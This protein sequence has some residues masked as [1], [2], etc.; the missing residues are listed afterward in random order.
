MKYY[1]FLFLICVFSACSGSKQAVENEKSKTAETKTEIKI[2]DSI[3]EK[4]VAIETIKPVNSKPKINDSLT[5][6]DIT[7]PIIG[8][9]KKPHH[10]DFNELLEA[11]VSDEGLVNYTGF[12]KRQSDLQN[13]ILY[14]GSSMP[15][16]SWTKEDKLAYWINAYNA[17]TIDL[18]LRHYP[19]KSIKDIKNPWDQ[20]LWKLGEKW[21][22]LNEIEHDILRKMDEPRIH[23]AI[24]CASFSCPKL[25]NK[26]FKSENLDGQLSEVTREFLSD[27]NRNDISE[28][29]IQLSKIFQ[30]FAK[31]F[32]QQGSLIDFLNVYSPTKISAKAKK[33]FKDYDWALNE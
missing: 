23:F 16:D 20:R 12:K 27:P 11:Y 1:S 32:K 9:L 31:D 14:L 7:Q 4:T 15:N 8:S 24:V 22:N 3:I 19:I 30:W 28:N 5:S 6:N 25:Q 29:D 17:M 21:Y 18:I 2:K 10:N 26:A 33:S 13:Y